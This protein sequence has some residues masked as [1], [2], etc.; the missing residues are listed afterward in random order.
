LRKGVKPRRQH[1][2]VHLPSSNTAPSSRKK[3]SGPNSAYY[4]ECEFYESLFAKR[5]DSAEVT[6]LRPGYQLPGFQALQDKIDRLVGVNPYGLAWEVLPLSWLVDLFISLD[7]VIDSVFLR[8]TSMFDV[9][10][11]ESLKTQYTCT[12]RHYYSSYSDGGFISPMDYHYVAASPITIGS[13]GYIRRT[14]EPPSPF[15]SARFRMGPYMAFL[16]LLVALGLVSS[17]GNKYVHTH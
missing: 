17:D 15:D 4:A 8:S 1:F 2:A 5:V 14:V 6:D 11:Y 13:S 16:S 7:D 3:Y 10:Y 9:V 12:F